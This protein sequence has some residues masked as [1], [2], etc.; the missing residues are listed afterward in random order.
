MFHGHCRAELSGRRLTGGR[1][2]GRRT[3][4]RAAFTLVPVFSQL[5][6]SFYECLL[7]RLVIPPP[8]PHNDHTCLFLE[9]PVLW[10]FFFLHTYSASNSNSVN[11]RKVKKSHQCCDNLAQKTSFFPSTTISMNIESAALKV[12]RQTNS[13][14]YI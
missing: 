6:E 12:S 8:S 10:L 14:T 13:Q 9:Q 1:G 2:R 3:W 7:W 11:N 4:C 5:S